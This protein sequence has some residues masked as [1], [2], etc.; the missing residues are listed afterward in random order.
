MFVWPVVVLTTSLPVLAG[1]ECRTYQIQYTYNKKK[2]Q[3][4]QKY[5][6]DFKLGK[7]TNLECNDL[8]C[9]KKLNGSLDSLSEGKKQNF[10]TLGFHLCH[11]L[12]GKA[13]I[14]KVLAADGKWKTMDRCSL[15]GV[16][17]V[18]TESL[19]R[20]FRN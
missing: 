16:G 8:G 10:G 4:K 13:Q 15:Q 17:V 19:V 6:I 20:Y 12:Y 1:S 2:Y 11:K 14:I 18:N 5:C 9:L 3:E 7:L